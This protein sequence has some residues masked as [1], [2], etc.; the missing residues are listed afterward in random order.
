MGIIGFVIFIFILYT[1]VRNGL[2]LNKYCIH[3]DIEKKINIGISLGMG[4]FFILYSFTGCCLYDLT[5]HMFILM[6]A[7]IMSY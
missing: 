7:M 5:F 2:T 4:I 1:Y 3:N 6:V